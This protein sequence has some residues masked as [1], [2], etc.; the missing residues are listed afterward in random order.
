M[1]ERFTTP[2]PEQR[3]YIRIA[4]ELDML[5]IK[6]KA[7]AEEVRQA[8]LAALGRPVEGL[9]S[10][11]EIFELTEKMKEALD[12]GYTEEELNDLIEELEEDENPEQQFDQI[13]ESLPITEVEMLMLESL[14]RDKKLGK[15]VKYDKNT[16]EEMDE[17]VIDAS[18]VDNTRG[19][20]DEL[21]YFLRT[22]EGEDVAFKFFEL[23]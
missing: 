23:E 20:A 1:S 9:M 14:L 6:I 2:P 13:V 12:H 17:L 5:V 21:I 3:E 10:R 16:D 18:K 8:P 15:L 19:L 22:R 11:P 7:T 4:N